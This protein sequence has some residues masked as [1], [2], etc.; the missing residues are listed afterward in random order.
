M[1]PSTSH[2]NEIPCIQGHSAKSYKHPPHEHR[3]QDA[4]ADTLRHMDSDGIQQPHQSY[5]GMSASEPLCAS[6]CQ[7][8]EPRNIDSPMPRTSVHYEAPHT[9]THT[10]TRK[11]HLYTAQL[12]PLRMHYDT[13]ASALSRIA[14]SQPLSTPSRLL[15]TTPPLA[16]D[17][18]LSPCHH[19]APSAARPAPSSVHLALWTATAVIRTT[20][21]QLAPHTGL[22]ARQ[23]ARQAMR[24]C[25]ISPMPA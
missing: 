6:R 12:A 25:Y 22:S 21:T 11:R 7:L 3:M 18:H 23:T 13:L 24:K 16:H 15:P 20:V 5:I 9:F 8:P 14:P 19:T 1:P 2:S 17:L 10:L 4:D